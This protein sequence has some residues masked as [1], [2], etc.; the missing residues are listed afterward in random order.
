MIRFTL[1]KWLSP[2]LGPASLHLKRFSKP[3]AS[4]LDSTHG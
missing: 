1:P 4:V 2:K 3:V